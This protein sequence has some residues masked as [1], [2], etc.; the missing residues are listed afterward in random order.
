MG[1]KVSHD[2]LMRMMV[3]RNNMRRF[4]DKQMRFSRFM[5]SILKDFTSFFWRLNNMTCHFNASFKEMCLKKQFFDP[6]PFE[7]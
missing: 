4:I 1:L 5:N 6:I 3:N 7:K 2:G